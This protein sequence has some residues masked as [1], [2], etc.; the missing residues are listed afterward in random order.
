[1]KTLKWYID[2]GFLIKMNS[3]KDLADSFLEKSRKNLITMSILLSLKTNKQAADLLNIPKDYSPNEWIVTTAYYSMYMASLAALAK[4]GYK[5]KNHIATTL[6]LEEFYVKKGLLEKEIIKLIEKARL[7]VNYIEMI[8]TAKDKREI[9][10]Y[11]PTKKTADSVAG[12]IKKDA[13]RFV[14]RIEKLISDMSA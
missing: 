10:Q 13:Y 3:A 8:R 4:I 9:A 14:E 1:M 6:A 7:E 11:S 2:N 12:S 5:S